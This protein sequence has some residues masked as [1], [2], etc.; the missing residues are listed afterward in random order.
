MLVFQGGRAR[1]PA[2]AVQTEVCFMPLGDIDRELHLLGMIPH[3]FSEAQK[4]MILPMRFA[5]DLYATMNHGLYTDV[6]YVRDFTRPD[7]MNADQLKHL[8]L[9]A[10]LPLVRPRREMRPRPDAAQ[11]SAGRCGGAVSREP[12]NLIA[13]TK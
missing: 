7:D 10:Q 11:R 1:L 2:V 4:A 12:A 13:A 6:L 3:I 8:A 5:N 9:I